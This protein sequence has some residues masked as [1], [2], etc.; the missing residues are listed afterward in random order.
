MKP[1]VDAWERRDPWGPTLRRECVR[2]PDGVA[3]YYEV[4]GRG[5]RTLVLANGLGGRL[6]AWAPLIEACWQDYRLMT[7]DYRGLF[8]SEVP[9]NPRQLS[10]EHHCRDLGA[11]LRAE[12]VG[13]AVL[14]GWSMGV[15][16]SLDVAATAP[17]SVAGLVLLNGTYGQVLS[18]AFQPL[19][20]VPWLPKRVHAVIE[21]LRAD[22]R[23]AAAVA[24]LWRAFELPVVA[25]M[26]VTMG[27][28]TCQARGLLRRYYDDVLGGSFRNYLRLF[29][30]LDAHSVYH[31]LPEIEAPAL[32]ISG[33]LDPLTPARQSVEIARRL[34][35]AEHLLLR[36][37]SHFALVERPEIVVPRILAFLERRARW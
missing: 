36:R 33:L 7:W 32:V 37:A 18:T 3:L 5:D 29:Q 16:V 21:Y 2:T 31:L 25:L 14:C 9:P 8:L 23:A 27:R 34:R 13:R 22:A 11:I 30:E 20:A 1:P 24:G 17:E 6:Y 35:D 15:Q 28:R 19:F 10:L 26:S 12:G 4:I